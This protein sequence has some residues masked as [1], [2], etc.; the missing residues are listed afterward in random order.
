MKRLVIG[1]LVACLC[2]TASA[3][4]VERDEQGRPILYEQ[5]QV[6]EEGAFTGVN[7]EGE[8]VRPRLDWF[9]GRPPGTFNPLIRFRVEF[10]PEMRASV[11]EVK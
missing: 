4:D 3:Q 10:L 8:L 1:G 9:G 6:L 2:G 5:R 7:I 11:D